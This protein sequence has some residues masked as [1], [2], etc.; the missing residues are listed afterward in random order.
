MKL[1]RLI[2]SVRRPGGEQVEEHLEQVHVL[3]GHI[4]DLEDGAHPGDTTHTHRHVRMKLLHLDSENLPGTD[5]A[6]L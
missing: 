3:S 6:P 4:G 2:V 1:C 5:S